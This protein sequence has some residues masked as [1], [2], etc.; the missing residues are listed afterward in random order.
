[1]A[2]RK[3]LPPA[4]DGMSRA[5]GQEIDPHVAATL[6]Q[7]EIKRGDTIKVTVRLPKGIKL[8]ITAIAEQEAGHKKAFNE[9]LIGLLEEGLSAYDAGRLRFTSKPVVVRTRLVRKA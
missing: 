1:M 7:K 6:Q 2:K 9:T 4:R 8:R 5:G 3:A